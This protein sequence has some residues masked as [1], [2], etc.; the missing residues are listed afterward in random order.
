MT[1]FSTIKKEQ[2]TKRLLY[3]SL[4]AAIGA[5]LLVFGGAM[6]PP[7]S[8]ALW[9]F[10][11]FLVAIGF[12]TCGM[13]PYRRLKR[14]ESDPYVIKIEGNSLSLL[15]GGKTLFHVNIPEILEVLYVE[16]GSRYGMELVL[17]GSP[18]KKVFIPY[19]SSASCRQIT[20]LIE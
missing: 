4:I 11:L 16:E 6:L 2:L 13:L 8:L 20:D 17:K 9:G 12:I 5:L 1:L 15:R 3:G 7:A 18:H 10:P 19:F 14:L